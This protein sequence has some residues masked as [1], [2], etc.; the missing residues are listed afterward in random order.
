M[1]L[2]LIIGELVCYIMIS[3]QAFTQE[4]GKVAQLL[5]KKITKRR[6][7]KNMITLTGQFVHF[8]AEMIFFL[9]FLLVIAFD[10]SNV[11]VKAVAMT[12][13]IMEFGVLSMVDVLTS[14]K[15][16]EAFIKDLRAL[17]VFPKQE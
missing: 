1:A 5:D 12:F 3:I 7:Q 15:L 8:V 11:Q 14:E 9:T 2:A 6:N 10:R 17:N 4:N 16:R 13:K